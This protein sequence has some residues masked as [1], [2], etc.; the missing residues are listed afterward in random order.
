V[1]ND[2]TAAEARATAE[3]GT[4]AAGRAT[5]EGVRARA[6]PGALCFVRDG[7]EALAVRVP[8]AA[9]AAAWARLRQ[10]AGIWEWVDERTGARLIVET[11]DRFEAAVTMA[12]PT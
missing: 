12:P 11:S 8:P 10:A 9:W 2:R 3:A 5:L 4:E 6:E 7:A 1:L